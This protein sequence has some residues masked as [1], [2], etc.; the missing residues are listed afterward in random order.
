MASRHGGVGAKRR[1]GRRFGGA[2][3]L[4]KQR[5]LACMGTW[6][7]RCFL[8]RVQSRTSRLLPTAGCSPGAHAH[9][10]VTHTRP[11]DKRSHTHTHA[12]TRS[13]AQTCPPSTRPAS[14][15]KI[16]SYSV[17]L[18]STDCAARP[19]GWPPCL[20]V[21][22]NDAAQRVPL[23]SHAPTAQCVALVTRVCSAS[24]PR[25]LAAPHALVAPAR[26]LPR[27]RCC[28]RSTGRRG[29]PP[30]AA[31]GRSRSACS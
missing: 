16:P 1:A 27:R 2:A 14:R 31:P 28:R 8:P 29:R 4:A 9:A 15:D 23:L 12:L 13:H 21:R 7:C 11:G 17:R 3:R 19:P 22:C 20:H 24:Q 18:A 5:R 10:D 6:T 25:L 30:R 26:L